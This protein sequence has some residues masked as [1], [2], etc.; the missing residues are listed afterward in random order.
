M[1]TLPQLPFREE[2][3]RFLE[4]PNREKFRELLRD[5]LGEFD[6][7]DF[8]ENWPEES[9]LAKHILAFANSGTGFIVVGVLE[10]EDG[11]HDIRGLIVLKDKTKLKDSVK[12]FLPESV[13]YNIFDFEYDAA[14]YKEISGK[15]FQLLCVRHDDES[16]P[17]LSLSD[18]ASIKRNRIY[19][20]H[21]NST[22]EAD[23]NQVQA[24]IHKRITSSRQTPKS[25][26]LHE[27]LSELEALYR[28]Q[29]VRRSLLELFDPAHPMQRFSDFLD[30]MVRLKESKIKELLES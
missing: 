24:L 27:H 16:I 23:H 7:L 30:Q 25:R 1:T 22:R 13:A 15:K 2:F 18:G 14:E 11:S 21:N 12:K 28:K 3:A 10:K 9:K 8:K 6:Y 29:P 17:I 5:R 4:V 20:R 19:V 26:K